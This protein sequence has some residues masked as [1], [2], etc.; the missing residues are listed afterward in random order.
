MNIDNYPSAILATG[1][2]C[3]M[4]DMGCAA[5]YTLRKAHCLERMVTTTICCVGS[6]GP[7]SNYHNGDIVLYLCEKCKLGL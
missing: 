3:L 6:V 2:A 7:H 5:V 4:A 1:R